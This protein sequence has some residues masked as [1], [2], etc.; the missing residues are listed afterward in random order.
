MKDRWF[1]VAYVLIVA[2]VVALLYFGPR[3]CGFK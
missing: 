3:S 1:N 2:A